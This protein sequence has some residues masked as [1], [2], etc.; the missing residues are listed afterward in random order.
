VYAEG[1]ES[2]LRV[3][4][5]MWMDGASGL[6]E[7][8]GEEGKGYTQWGRA[9]GERLTWATGPRVCFEA[10][11]RERQTQDGRTSRTQQEKNCG[12]RDKVRPEGGRGG[13]KH[14][15]KAGDSRAPAQE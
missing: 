5:G 12:S 15:G 4:Q 9:K 11:D 2:R 8:D 10:A 7:R 14:R 1:K 13:R 6:I 3:S